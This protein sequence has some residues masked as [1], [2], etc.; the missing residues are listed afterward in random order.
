MNIDPALQTDNDETDA[1]SDGEPARR[2]RGGAI[3][4][5]S[6]AAVRRNKPGKSIKAL[7]AA[8]AAGRQANNEE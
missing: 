5:K 1:F 3:V 7:A 2:G 8:A 6:V 4:T